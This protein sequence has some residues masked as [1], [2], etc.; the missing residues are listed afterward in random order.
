[1][2]SRKTFALLSLFMLGVL[3]TSTFAKTY[4]HHS[5]FSGLTTLFLA[6]PIVSLLIGI[7]FKRSKVAFLSLLLLA[8][9]L[10]LL[11]DKF[12]DLTPDQVQRAVAL[13]TPVGFLILGLMDEKGF[14]KNPIILRFGVTLLLCAITYW[15]GSNPAFVNT[16]NNPIFSEK[17]PI[18]LIS[19][20]AFVLYG[21]SVLFLSILSFLES[22]QVEKSLPWVLFIAAF[23]ILLPDSSLI[24]HLGGAG[25]IFSFAL[26]QDAY[27]MSYIDALT[28]IPS[29]RAMDEYFERLS[30]PFTIAMTDIDHFKKFNDTYGHDVGDDVLRKIAQTLKN[31]DGNGRVFR[32]GGE[33]FAV[34]FAGKEARSCKPFLEDIKYTIQKQGFIVRGEDRASKKSR[35]NAG[36]KVTLTIS[37]GACDHSW[38]DKIQNILKKADELLYSAKKAG[39]NCVKI[40]PSK[41]S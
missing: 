6:P 19:E 16:L 1:M 27:K 23:P 17:F 18:K 20:I 28:G 13:M 38:G 5:L 26:S 7:H 31:I 3:L 22:K 4:F 15:L 37:I 12:L 30:P 41:R 8:F 2:A 21:A 32:Y 34:V 29:R 11:F 14:S 9:Q 24:W 40:A 35:K 39:R 36:T 25:I 33:E 10:F